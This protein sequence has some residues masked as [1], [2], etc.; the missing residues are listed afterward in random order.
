MRIF[1]FCERNRNIWNF[2]SIWSRD[3]FAFHQVNV[4]IWI[5]AGKRSYWQWQWKYVYYHT[6]KKSIKYY[7]LSDSIH[8]KGGMKPKLIGPNFCYT[9]ENIPFWG[10]R[11]REM[12][13]S[14]RRMTSIL[15]N[16]RSGVLLIHGQ[17]RVQT[18]TKQLALIWDSI[19][20]S[21]VHYHNRFNKHIVHTY[22][23]ADI[24]LDER[25]L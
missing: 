10:C 14:E 16:L 13:H 4:S 22:M 17:E 12:V 15:L 25:V 7:S 5:T 18:S 24:L 21:G 8:G 11:K 9:I 19:S 2:R 1:K 6:L 3:S 23:Q 20:S